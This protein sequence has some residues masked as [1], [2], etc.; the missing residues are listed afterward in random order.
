ME[1]EVKSPLL[2]FEEITKMKLVK[3]DDVF[4]KLQAMNEKEHPTFTLVNPY[5]LREYTFDMPSLVIDALELKEDSNILILNI[6]VVQDP[7]AS[8]TVNFA[9]PII[10]N[11]DNNTMT[12]TILDTATNDYGIA[13]PISN[14]IQKSQEEQQTEQS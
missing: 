6:V 1:F 14:F 8:S 13:E 2:G 5:V 3:I 9:A 11:I 10:F 4:M 7:I 12:Q